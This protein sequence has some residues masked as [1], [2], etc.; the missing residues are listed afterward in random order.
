MTREIT[1]P[2]G[3]DQP[4]SV[5][6]E[7]AEEPDPDRHVERETP[8]SIDALPCAAHGREQARQRQAEEA[9]GGHLE[10]QAVRIRRDGEACRE[11]TEPFLEPAGPAARDEPGA[12]GRA[13]V[14]ALPRLGPVAKAPDLDADG[15]ASPGAGQPEQAC[16]NAGEAAFG[17]VHIGAAVEDDAV[18][19]R[20]RRPHRRRQDV[21]ARAE[22]APEQRLDGLDPGRGADS[23]RRKLGRDAPV[24]DEAGARPSAAEGELRPRPAS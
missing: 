15:E 23:I 13:G 16:R 7:A 9:G 21:E 20:V 3:F 11:R 6:G 19:D 4:A 22:D 17:A 10:G 1:V 18:R 14:G 2:L 5:V 12:H 24:G 8:L